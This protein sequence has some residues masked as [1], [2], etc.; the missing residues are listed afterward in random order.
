[1]AMRSTS[2]SQTHKR[3]SCQTRRQ[4][5]AFQVFHYQEIDFGFSTYVVE[6]ANVGVFG[7]DACR[8]TMKGILGAF[9]V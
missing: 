6:N 1:M 3:F 4:R 7:S 5:L 9:I 8:A 2:S